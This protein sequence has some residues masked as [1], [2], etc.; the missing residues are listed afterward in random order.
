MKG[1]KAGVYYIIKNFKLVF[2]T[3]Y[4]AKHETNIDKMGRTCSKQEREQ[5]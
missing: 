1:Q 5:I 2:V 4:Y 3:V